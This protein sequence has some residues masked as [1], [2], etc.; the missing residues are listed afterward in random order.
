MDQNKENS[1]IETDK[2][3]EINQLEQIIYSTKLCDDNYDESLALAEKYKSEGK[4]FFPKKIL[5]EA[6][7][8]YSAVI[9]L[10]V[11]TKK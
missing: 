6:L 11:K 4:T 1:E 8:K 9:D 5:L 10:K 7:Q 3:D 2:K